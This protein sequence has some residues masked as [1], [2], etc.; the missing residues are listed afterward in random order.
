MGEIFADAAL[1][2]ADELTD[3]SS[4]LSVTS[5]VC[6]ASRRV[7]PSNP[8]MENEAT[9]EEE[10]LAALTGAFFSLAALGLVDI[11][12]PQSDS[13]G[14]VWIFFF[15]V[16]KRCNTQYYSICKT[17]EIIGAKGYGF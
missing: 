17:I 7:S 13:V 4:L 8:S 2:D 6:L 9:D 11:F 5:V 14:T 10:E 1:A 12:I 15:T 16:G 3:F